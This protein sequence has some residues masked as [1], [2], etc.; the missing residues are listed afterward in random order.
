MASTHGSKLSLVLNTPP[1][2]HNPMSVL[3]AALPAVEPPQ[4][5]PLRP[6][7]ATTVAC[8]QKPGLVLP[9]DGAPLVFSTA[10]AHGLTLRLAGPKGPVDLPV[11]AD[12]EKGGLVVDTS[13][14]DPA[15]LA[16]ALEG[17]LHG[18]WGFE[19]FDG[20]RFR[21]QTAAPEGWRVAADD[22]QALIVGRDDSLRLDGAG[23]AC[24]E[25]VAIQRAADGPQPLDWRTGAADQLVVNTPLQA[26]DPGPMTLL[27]KSYG[28]KAPDSVALQAFA[29][30]GRLDSFAYHAGDAFGV[31]KGTR[32]DEVSGLAF[33]G[34]IFRPGALVSSDGADSLTLSV[35]G[36][37]DAGALKLGQSAAAKVA[38]KDGRTLNLKVAVQPPRPSVELIGKSVQSPAPTAGDPIR[39]AGDDQLPQGAVLT[40]SIRAQAP[41]AF[42]GHETLEV[43]SAG[44]GATAMLTPAAGLTFED[45]HVA[46][47]TLDTSKAFGTSAFGP[48]RFRIVDGGVAGDWRPLATLV[49]LPVVRELTCP[50]G[51]DRPCALAGS[52]LFLLDSVSSGPGF[53]NAA[54]VPE[55]YTG[56]ALPVP[57][58]SAGRLFVRLHDDPSVVNQ[59]VLPDAQAPIK[60]ARSRG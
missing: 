8:A 24:V 1:S 55:G 57:H 9:V 47:A 44:G 33:G 56:S 29:Q 42:S 52:D 46:L 48:L 11:Q 17:T 32:L 28:A 20:P 13:A 41:A 15:G 25:S 26:A 37:Q 53:D 19:P 22:Q 21:L 50:G 4:A 40:F 35:E 16:A 30:P 31:L 3:V 49:R 14:L 36:G 34:A 58:P 10:Y 27:V 60:S 5:P 18:Y 51:A 39:L 12:A 38:L 54:H 59:I 45:P 23:A 43:A 7:D 2:F 6:V